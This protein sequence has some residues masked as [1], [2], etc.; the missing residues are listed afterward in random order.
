MSSVQNVTHAGQEDWRAMASTYRLRLGSPVKLAG[1]TLEILMKLSAFGLPPTL[2]TSYPG[3]LVQKLV[4]IPTLRP[5]PM[6]LKS[7]A[8]TALVPSALYNYR[9][10]RPQMTFELFRLLLSCKRLQTSGNYG[11]KPFGGTVSSEISHRIEA[12]PRSIKQD[13]L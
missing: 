2:V 7:M 5:L 1:K 10:G 13:C 11:Q 9:S 6:T 4:V 3:E 12:L 8:G